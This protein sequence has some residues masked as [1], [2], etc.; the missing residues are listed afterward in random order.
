[1]NIKRFGFNVL[2]KVLIDRGMHRSNSVPA[3]IKD[4]SVTQIESLGGVFRIIPT[5]TKV[6]QGT[7]LTINVDP[8]VEPGKLHK[9]I[10]V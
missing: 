7:H 5:T 4:E 1:M 10:R 8:T 3:L 9:S 2:Q 6:S